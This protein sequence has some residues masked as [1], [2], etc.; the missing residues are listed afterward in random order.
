MAQHR[1]STYALNFMNSLWVLALAVSCSQLSTKSTNH[2]TSSSRTMRKGQHNKYDNFPFVVIYIWKRQEPLLLAG[3]FGSLPNVDIPFQV[4]QKRFF[5][6]LRNPVPKNQKLWIRN[7]SLKLIGI[8]NTRNITIVLYTP[9]W[10]VPN[11]H[12]SSSSNIWN[13]TCS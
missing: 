8:S 7:F 9:T 13:G 5:L 2:D 3:V 11:Y 10:D 4:Q 12:G 1:L 6:K